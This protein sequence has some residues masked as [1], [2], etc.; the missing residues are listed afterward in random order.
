MRS[1]L[2]LPSGE[3]NTLH[4]NTVNIYRVNPS[5]DYNSIPALGK[6]ELGGYGYLYV[7]FL[8]FLILRVSTESQLVRN[9][10]LFLFH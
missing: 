3:N 10:F 6:V 5:V 4:P 7:I 2:Q 9:K 8:I 1:Y